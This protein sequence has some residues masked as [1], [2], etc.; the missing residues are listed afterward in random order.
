MESVTSSSIVIF[1]L[2]N[3]KLFF[4]LLKIIVGAE[5]WTGGLNPG[6]LWIWSGSA[7]PVLPKRPSTRPE[8]TV[9]GG[10]RCL[11]LAYSTTAHLYQYHGAECSLRQRYVCELQE[12]AATR[13]LRRLHKSLKLDS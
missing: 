8:D 2:D 9:V 13:A 1:T 11:K 7:Q 6:L 3:C 10:G 5:W 4:D 12:N